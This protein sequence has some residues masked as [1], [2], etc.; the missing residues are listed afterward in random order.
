MSLSETERGQMLASLRRMGLAG[1][2]EAVTLQPLTGG[3]SSL[4]VLATPAGGPVCV[5]TALPQLRVAAQWLA[6]V[7]RNHAEVAWL[8]WVAGIVPERVPAV[9]GEDPVGHAFAMTWLDPERHP[10]WKTEL[11]E[12]RADPA[13]AAA[14]ARTL[15]AIHQASAGRPDL[16]AAFAHD[17]QFHAL[18]LDPYLGAAAL[19]H[20]DCAPALRGLI[21]RTAGNRIALVHGDVSPKNILC[22]PRGPVVLDAECAWYGDPAFDLAFLLNHL[23]LKCAWR[24]A[25]AAAYLAC[26]RAA[27]QAYLDAVGWEDPDA[28]QARVAALIGGLLLARVDGKSPVE[29]LD[30]EALRAPVRAAARHLVL[31]PAPHLP[32]LVDTWRALMKIPA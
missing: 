28:L 29:Y 30:T 11:R 15:A 6:P 2:Q 20:P 17:A 25:H 14:V 7:E 26:L 22:G 12:G 21:T 3:V 24:P 31:H 1:P 16:A 19:A 5:K 9:L 13:L 8:R 23:L 32:A 4:I 18:R 10:V 27:A